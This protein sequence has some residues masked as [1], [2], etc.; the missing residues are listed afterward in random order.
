MKRFYGALVALAVLLVI[1]GVWGAYVV[2]N[3]PPEEVDE[4]PQIF[5]FEKE[6][7]TGIKIE[8]TDQTI[9]FKMGGDG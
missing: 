9:E 8:R 3:Q 2:L 6:D 7:L 1:G 5:A 4:T